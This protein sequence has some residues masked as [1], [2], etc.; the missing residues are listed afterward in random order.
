M[1]KRFEPRPQKREAF[2]ERSK[3]ERI[4]AKQA[5]PAAGFAGVRIPAGA[6]VKIPA[7]SAGI[8]AGAKD[9]IRGGL[10]PLELP[11]PYLQTAAIGVLT[12]CRS[13]TG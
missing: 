8:F 5:A 13:K 12:D 2:F 9:P 11:F 6:P 3:A 10:R 1:F 7:I 4:A